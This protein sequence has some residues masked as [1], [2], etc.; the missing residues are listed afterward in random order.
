MGTS[1]KMSDNLYWDSSSLQIRDNIWNESSSSWI[2]AAHSRTLA[3]DFRWVDCGGFTRYIDNSGSND[4][5]KG[6]PYS[7]TKWTYTFAT[8]FKATPVVVASVSSTWA[9][10]DCAF[11]ALSIGTTLRESFEMKFVNGTW[12][13]ATTWNTTFILGP[14]WIAVG[15]LQ[16]TGAS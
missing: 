6:P 14:Q 10:P 12:D 5:W 1:I 13:G 7:T 16:D 8:R 3:N 9:Y 4:I 2:P 15:S 11:C